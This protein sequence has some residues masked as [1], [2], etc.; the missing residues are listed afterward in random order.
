[1]D[2]VGRV[3]LRARRKP[4]ERDSAEDDLFGPHFGC[5]G[6]DRVTRVR[7][8]AVRIDVR[9]ADAA[10]RDVDGVGDER[11]GCAA[12]LTVGE[13]QNHRTVARAQD[14]VLQP[15]RALA[16]VKTPAL[17]VLTDVIGVRGRDGTHWIERPGRA[18]LGI[19]VA[20]VSGYEAR[21]ELVGKIR[22]ARLGLREKLSAGC[23]HY[24]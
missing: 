21:H 18:N 23:I 5:L 6:I 20:V 15:Q 9:I 2:P 13:A 3:D 17:R 19:A 8:V 7:D 4:R 24:R 22:G 1:M 10:E 11:I 12:G 16:R 14:A